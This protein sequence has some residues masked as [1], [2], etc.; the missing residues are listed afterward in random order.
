[1]TDPVDIDI[2]VGDLVRSESLSDSLGTVMRSGTGA[3]KHGVWV[4]WFRLGDLSCKHERWHPKC[5][6]VR[7][8][9]RK[10]SLN[11]D[12]PLET[13]NLFDTSAGTGYIIYTNK[14]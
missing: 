11:Q 1:M 6:L 10:R 14:D 5:F 4:K 9:E 8:S 3:N 13:N 2:R 12:S 7:L